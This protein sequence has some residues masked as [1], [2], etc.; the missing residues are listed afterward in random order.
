LAFELIQLVN[1]TFLDIIHLNKF[2][3]LCHITLNIQP[4]IIVRIA[5]SL[6]KKVSILIDFIQIFVDLGP[7]IEL[8]TDDIL[9][10]SILHW[11]ALDDVL[12]VREDLTH[13]STVLHNLV[14]KSTLLSVLCLRLDGIL[15][16][17]L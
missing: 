11:L 16:L 6:E 9:L 3:R 14:S 17:L 1:T 2:N 7:V 15:D 5:A 4:N 10:P 12:S 13:G 8:M